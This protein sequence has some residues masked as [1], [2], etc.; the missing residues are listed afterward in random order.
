MA[1]LAASLLSAESFSRSLVR[2]V[3]DGFE[4][5]AGGDGGEPPKARNSMRFQRWCPIRRGIAPRSR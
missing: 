4:L 3:E 1:E 2:A 5:V